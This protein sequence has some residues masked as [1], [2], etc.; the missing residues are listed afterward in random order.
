MRLLVVQLM[1]FFVYFQELSTWHSIRLSAIING[2]PDLLAVETI[3]V[4]KEAEAIL[5]SLTDFPGVK[6]YISFQ[7]NVCP[8][9][10]C[11]YQQLYYCIYIVLVI[12]VL[13]VLSGQLIVTE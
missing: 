4:L 10:C 13:I 12:V 6:A 3:P 8:M 7:C 11:N 2:G 9:N 1:V 5:M